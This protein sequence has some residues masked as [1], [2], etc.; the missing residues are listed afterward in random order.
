MEFV[1]TT[2]RGIEDTAKQEI[3]ELIKEDSE[4]IAP[5]RLKFSA[6]EGKAKELIYMAKSL[7]MVYRLEAKFTFKSIDEIVKKCPDIKIKGT[8]KVKCARYTP[9]DFKSLDVEKAV[10]EKYFNKGHKVDLDK[11]ETV[12][13]IE[14][15]DDICFV[16][17]DITR[18]EMQKRE[19]RLKTNNQSPNALLAYALIRMSG[20]KKSMALLDPFCKDGVIPIEAAL[21]ACNVP[22]GYFSDQRIDKLDKK[23]KKDKLEITGYDAYMPNVKNAEIN[24]KLAE[25][26]KQIKFSRVEVDWLDVK[27]PKNS[28]DVIA[29][30][31][32]F[33]SK[34]KDSAETEKDYKQL[35]HQ[36]EFVLKKKGCLAIIAHRPDLIKK[37]A[38]KFV[39]KQETI[40]NIG[41]MAISLMVYAK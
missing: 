37:Y 32:S 33:V 20:W 36:A 16:G 7:N 18:K 30:A 41:D 27:F 15:I 3:K 19:Y 21:Y 1:A 29:T 28:I 22:R 8:F 10:G 39:L 9:Q 40:A 25:V 34:G 35:F 31:P 14:I 13:Y 4:L 11:P 38:E 24:A 26:T 17:I 6:T 23:I 12:I 5:G 2:V